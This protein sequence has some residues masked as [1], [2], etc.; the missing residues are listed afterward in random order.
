MM[1]QNVSLKNVLTELAHK[2][3]KQYLKKKKQMK[4]TP[5]T[6][7]HTPADFTLRKTEQ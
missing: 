2:S 3:A 1:P 6:S 5:S 7:L 4:K